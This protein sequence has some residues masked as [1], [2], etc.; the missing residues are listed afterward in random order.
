[1]RARSATEGGTP[2][3]PPGREAGG[4][5]PRFCRGGASDASDSA[6]DEPRAADDGEASALALAAA[7]SQAAVVERARAELSRKLS[8]GVT[9]PAYPRPAGA[10]LPPRGAPP[11]GAPPP[12]ARAA[13]SDFDASEE[14]CGFST[15]GA[16]AASDSGS[17]LAR[18]QPRSALSPRAARHPAARRRAGDRFVDAPAP[19][20]AAEGGRPASSS[21]ARRSIQLARRRKRELEKIIQN[22][23][24]EEVE[25]ADAELPAVQA[26]LARCA[27]AHTHAR[28][29]EYAAPHTRSQGL[30]NACSRAS[31]ASALPSFRALRVCAAAGCML[32]CTG[33][34]WRRSLRSGRR[35]TRPQRHHAR[36]AAEGEERAARTAQAQPWRQPRRPRRTQQQHDARTRARTRRG[37]HDGDDEKHTLLKQ[38]PHGNA[39]SCRTTQHSTSAPARRPPTKKKRAARPPL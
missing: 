15:E 11:R 8:L 10:A 17:V 25:A 27:R 29:R 32:S 36:A 4:G 3:P 28:Q 21:S 5:L 20:S 9:L 12:G 37:T 34:S 31:C 35:G 13:A 19:S 18:A 26:A 22:G 30:T 33:A 24:A 6:R 14:S 2:T 39:A 1:L 38:T 23:N 7:R 16:E